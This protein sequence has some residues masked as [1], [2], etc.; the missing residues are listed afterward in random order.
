MNSIIEYLEKKKMTKGIE[1]AKT[2]MECFEP[3]SQDRG[4][5]YADLSYCT[6]IMRKSTEM[7]TK[8]KKNVPN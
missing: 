4:H 8:S 5:S 7:L 2:T 1:I 6:C 3:Y